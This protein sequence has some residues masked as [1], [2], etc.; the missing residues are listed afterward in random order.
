MLRGLYLHQ[1][2]KE[3]NIMKYED[4]IKKSLVG[5][6]L[7]KNNARFSNKV[8]INFGHIGRNYKIGTSLL[9]N[10]NIYVDS[11]KYGYVKKGEKIGFEAAYKEG[12]VEFDTKMSLVIDK[13]YLFRKDN[14]VEYV[15]N[16]TS[17]NSDTYFGLDIPVSDKFNLGLGIRHIGI[18]GIIDPKKSTNSNGNEINHKIAK[19]DEHN[20]PIGKDGSSIITS[21][22]TEKNLVDREYERLKKEYEEKN[23]STDK[24]KKNNFNK[25]KRDI[26]Q[27]D[28]IDTV[29]SFAVKSKYELYN[30]V[31]S[32][33]TML[34]RPY[35][36]FIFSSHLEVPVSVRNSSPAGIRG[37]YAGEIK[38]LIDDSFADIVFTKQNPIKFKTSGNVDVG[39]I[40]GSDVKQYVSYK[41]MS[42]IGFLRGDIKGDSKNIDISLS[43]NPLIVNFSVKPRLLLAKEGKE[44]VTKTGLEYSKDNEFSSILGFKKVIKSTKNIFKDELKPDVIR[45]LKTR[46]EKEYEKVKDKVDKVNFDGVIDYTLTPFIDIKKEEGKFRISVKADSIKALGHSESEIVNEGNFVDRTPTTYFAWNYLIILQHGLEL[47]LIKNTTIL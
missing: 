18:Y 32:R 6:D 1:S 27:S 34:Y 26:H 14:K 5:L 15:Y 40:L 35:N 28:Y 47:G 33:I 10:D 30:I 29:E 17:F 36:N 46:K 31:S 21:K 8:I 45:I 12:I 42:D 19:R 2:E 16:T 23:P 41:A 4:E 20:N 43:L 3:K 13:N 44:I 22:T 38:Y 24:N 9:I 39:L 7:K 11:D 25:L 37:V